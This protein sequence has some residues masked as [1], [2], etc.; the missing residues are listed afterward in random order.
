MGLDW[1]FLTRRDP[2]CRSAICMEVYTTLDAAIIREVTRFVKPDTCSI[3]PSLQDACS[4]AFR[5]RFACGSVAVPIASVVRFFARSAKKRTTRR[6][7]H[8]A[9]YGGLYH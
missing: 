7:E 2:I 4:R 1:P 5:R 8:T 6:R 9:N 3:A